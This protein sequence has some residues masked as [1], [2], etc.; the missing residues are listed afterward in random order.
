MACVQ[1]SGFSTSAL[2]PTRA[3][4]CSLSGHFRSR[5]PQNREQI[6]LWKILT[7]FPILSHR[8][9]YF[10]TTQ[11]NYSYCTLIGSYAWQLIWP[12]QLVRRG[13]LRLKVSALVQNNSI[14]PPG[15]QSSFLRTKVRTF[16]ELSMLFDEI[17]LTSTRLSQWHC[18]VRVY[19]L[20]STPLLWGG[21]E[22]RTS[23]GVIFFFR[24]ALNHH[25]VLSS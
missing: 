6:L 8:V 21:A 12:L 3:E 25:G 15:G 13:L 23:A 24:F 20:I 16:H 10:V 18:K 14:P 11:K 9:F 17:S 2:H 4:Q 7:I 5:L 22:G 1:K 19:R